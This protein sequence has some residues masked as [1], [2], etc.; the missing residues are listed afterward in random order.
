M[1]EAALLAAIRITTTTTIITIIFPAGWKLVFRA[2]R[3]T[4]DVLKHH[5]RKRFVP[6]RRCAEI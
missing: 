1:A 5:A 4:L 2:E 3:R 6:V